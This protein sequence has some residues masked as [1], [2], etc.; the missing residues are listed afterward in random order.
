[1]VLLQNAHPP[2]CHNLEDRLSCWLLEKG[3]VAAAVA[4]WKKKKLEDLDCW[5]LVYLHFYLNLNLD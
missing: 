5:M 2:R 4:G 1:M 3:P